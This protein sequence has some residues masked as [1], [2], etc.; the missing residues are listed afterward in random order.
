MK[1]STHF[2]EHTRFFVACGSSPEAQLTTPSLLT[3]RIED[4]SGRGLVPGAI[5]PLQKLHELRGTI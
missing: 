3:E 1:S 4:D 5:G 2:H